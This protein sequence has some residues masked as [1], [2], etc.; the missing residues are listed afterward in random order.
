MQDKLILITGGSSG[1]GK[2]T[3]MNLHSQGASIIIQ[4]RGLEKLKA[5]A[6]EIDVKG[7]RISYYSTDLT[8]QTAVEASANA[9]IEKEGLPDVIINSAG[10]GEWLSFKEADVAHFKNTMN[11]PYLATALTC[12]VFYDKMQERG[13]G[14]FVIVNSAGSY[15]T[16]QG[17]T[18]YLPARWAML[19]FA[20]ALEADLHSSKF[21]VSLVALGKVNSPYF[22]NN[23][24]SEE[25]IPKISNWLTPT[26][27]EKQAG[28]YVSEVVKSKRKT[29]IRPR[30]IS[31]FVFLNRFFPR[32]FIVLMRT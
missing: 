10:G 12:K 3:A 8:N 14:H 13:T 30:I 9:I 17:A 7:N 15:F 5:A 6:N 25:R 18:G 4:A 16:F 28:F 1:I 19:G 21:E 26:M 23:P 20:K 2:A 31:F 27:S 24:K 11:S 22:E 32:L 29:T